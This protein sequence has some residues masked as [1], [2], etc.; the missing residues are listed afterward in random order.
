MYDDNAFKD[1]MF[2]W[3]ENI[4]SWPRTRAS[5]ADAKKPSRAA[6]ELDPLL[7]KQPQV[8][9]LDDQSF[10]YEFMEFLTRLVV[11]CNWHIHSDT[12]YKHLRNNEP[13]GDATCRMRMDG[14]LQEK[15]I[16]DKESGSIELWQ[17]CGHINNFMD[18][19]LF[20]MQ[21]NTDTQFIGS[22]EAAKAAV[23][24]IT[25]YITKGDVP[26]Y[27]GLQ[28]LDYATKMHE[29]KYVDIED[30]S[31]ARMAQNLIMKLVN[32]MMGRQETSHQQVMS[33]LVGGGDHYTSHTFQTFKWFEFTNAIDKF[34][35]KVCDLNNDDAE[36]DEESM[37]IEESVT[38][39]I[40]SETFMSDV[41]DYMLR[42]LDENFD[43]FCLWDFME[44]TVKVKGKMDDQSTNNPESDND[45]FGEEITDKKH[46]H[47]KMP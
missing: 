40:S 19:I 36:D 44:S 9:D 34:E 2:S 11:E 30:T 33:Y 31:D 26:L 12:C 41:Q 39:G 16:I 37:Y 1:V 24:Y 23:F 38:V 6:G 8:V 21:C 27:I 7:D 25:K 43:Q 22:G 4:I 42:P 28:V 47:K 18:L 20:L 10:Q 3:L 35:C 14:K 45:L 29:A 5:T 46:K 13:R 17:W 32:A 15:T